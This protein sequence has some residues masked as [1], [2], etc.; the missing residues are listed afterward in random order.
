MP[1]RF[2]FISENNTYQELFTKIVYI[3]YAF[4]GFE[5]DFQVVTLMKNSWCRWE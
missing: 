1:F 4:S 5:K 2:L 3:R